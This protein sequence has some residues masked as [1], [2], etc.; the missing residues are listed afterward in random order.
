MTRIGI[1]LAEVLDEVEAV[2][3]DEGVEARAAVLAHLVLER[4]HAPRCEDA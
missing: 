1:S 2:G 3:A 4:V